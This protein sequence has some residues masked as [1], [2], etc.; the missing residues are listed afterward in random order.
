MY[1]AEDDAPLDESLVSVSQESDAHS[2]SAP[3]VGTSNTALVQADSHIQAAL[4]LCRQ[5]DLLQKPAAANV[6]HLAAML[7]YR[8]GDL[9]AAE[10]T[11]QKALQIAKRNGQT[12][13]AFRCLNYLGQIAVK[14]GN[15]DEAEAISREAVDL[16]AVIQAY[17]AM[18]YMALVNRA[19]FCASSGARTMRWIVCARRCR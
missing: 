16:Q 14:Q 17:P 4:D 13:V 1:L 15:L 3:T 2:Q 5:H 10:E 9:A 19:K 6:W 18:H 7:Q 11:W 12:P 8:R